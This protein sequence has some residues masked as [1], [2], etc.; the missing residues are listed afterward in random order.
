MLKKLT[1]G[2]GC[3]LRS[4]ISWWPVF[5][6][7]KDGLVVKDDEELKRRKERK[8][9]RIERGEAIVFVCEDE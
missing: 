9:E 2:F 1:S 3:K 7:G 5:L 4:L 6:R 8:R